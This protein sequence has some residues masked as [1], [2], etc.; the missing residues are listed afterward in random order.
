MNVI[1]GEQAGARPMVSPL[2]QDLLCGGRELRPAQV[3]MA[4]AV[5]RALIESVPAVIEAPTGV[6]KSHA[7]LVPA[8]RS[9]KTIVISTANKALQEQLF[10]KDVPYL[11]KHLQ[12]FGVA[13]LKGVG[14]YLCLDRLHEASKDLRTFDRFSE[15]QQLIDAV[16]HDGTFRGDF[17]TLGFVLPGELRARV[18]GD[19][20]Q[21]AWSKCDWFDECYVRSM[22]DRARNAQVIIVNHT[23]LLLDAW[24]DNAIIPPHDVV[25]IDEAHHLAEEA[26]SAFTVAVRPTQVA[27]LL[28]LRAV[29]AHTPEILRREVMQLSAQLWSRIEHTSFGTTG[30][31][32]FRQPFGEALLLAAKLADV[33]EALRLRRPAEQSE[34]EAALYDKV[35]TR[36][37]NLSNNV[38]LV[39]SVESKGHY[40]H[41]LERVLTGRERFPSVQACAAPLNVAPFLREKLFDKKSIVIL[42]SATLATIGPHPT[43]PQE[44]GKPNFAY[45]RKQIGL[46]PARS[47]VIERVLPQV[48]DYRSHA[49]LYVPR[50]L[51]EPAYV[52][53]PAQH[54]TGV[55]AE[56]M[57][58]LVL[59]SRGRA[60]LLFSSRRMLDDVYKRIVADLPYRVL[61]QG[62]MNRLDIIKRF[63]EEGAVLFGLKTFWEGVDIEGS[64]LSLVVIDRLPFAPPDD[65]IH[66]A[67]VNGMKARGENWFGAYVLPQVVLSLKQGVGRLLRTSEDRGVMAI[68][69]ARLNTKGYGRE[70][71][72]ALPGATRTSQ[73]ADVERFFAQV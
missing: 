6:G 9:G 32:T 62:E 57:K 20:D 70:V 30:R 71:L 51:P 11:Q 29:Q 26:T 63:R 42:T 7:Y 61:R 5:Q 48:F 13:M 54:Y 27:S 45:L 2:V 39:F 38:R 65:P 47:E 8:I 55:I 58:G 22:R 50:D 66:E 69:D 28:Q 33:A 53:Q 1:P 17:E 41:Y 15:F 19:S 24:V 46:D 3:E 40:V 23:L 34:K 35:I 36:T 10:T 21:C 59:A 68:L 37:L 64:A 16:E 44:S 52:G 60:F 4:M 56:R 67:I 12:P 18:N 25:V 73:L 72:N 49:L 43:R 14:N 31:V